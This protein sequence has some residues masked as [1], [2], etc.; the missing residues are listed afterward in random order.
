MAVSAPA[1]VAGNAAAEVRGSI[2][3]MSPRVL[4]VTNDF[5]PKVGG[6]Q[7][8]QEELC[9]RLDPARLAVLASGHPG[10]AR[11]D[12]SLPYRVRRVRA[13]TLLPGRHLA[14]EVERACDRFEPDVVVFGSALPL[15]LLH[16]IPRRRGIP[17]AVMVYGADVSVPARLPGAHTALRSVLAAADGVVALGPFVAAEVRKA[18]PAM[19]APLLEIY[20]GVDTDRFTPG[21]ASVARR[22]LGLDA[23]R[24]TIT[25]VS[26]LVPRKGMHQLVESA[27]RLRRRFPDL[28]VAIG[29]TGRDQRRLVRRIGRLGLGSTVTLLGRVPDDALADLYRAGDVC[30]MLCHDRWL[31]MEAEGFGIVFVEA[32]ACARPVVAGRSG[33]AAD[34]V[35]DGI[36][37]A[38]VDATDPAAVDS[39]LASYLADPALARRHGDAGRERAVTTFRWDVQAPRFAAWLAETFPPGA[40]VTID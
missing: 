11:F 18:C 9:A 25:S 36:N 13:E 31:G 32:A 34:A 21:P 7:V 20:P 2:G 40:A 29:G 37:G 23:D 4:L 3:R 38:V 6:I 35:A 26:R 33:G 17:H 27:A 16:A 24:P 19:R 12:A 22:R 14:R 1:S 30:T 15:G 28:Q 39:A 5:P 8:V 10:A